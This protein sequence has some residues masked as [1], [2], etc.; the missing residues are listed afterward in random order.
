MS[1]STD[2]VV[3]ALSAA[4]AAGDSLELR[5]ALGD[6]YLALGIGADALAQFEAGLMLSAASSAAL[7]GAVLAA[8]LCGDTARASAY[9]LAAA[10]VPPPV[11]ALASVTTL[12]PTPAP[13]PTPALAPETAA[14]PASTPPRPA[15]T[16]SGVPAPGK[17]PRDS[18][19]HDGPSLRLVSDDG[20]EA[21]P[22]VTFANVGGMEEVKQRLT[23]SFLLPLRNPELVRRF[24]KST[25]GGLLLYGPPGCGK[26]FLARAVAGEVGARF[27]NIG[28]S[29]VLDMW[30]GESERKLHELFENARRG[31]PTLIFL[32]EVDALGQRRSNMKGGAGR[33]LVNQLLSEMDGMAGDNEGVFFLA[34]T[35][36]PWDVDPALRRPGRFD[37][38]V[39][40]SP[41]DEIA[42]RSIFLLKLADR[43]C[44]QDI[45][46]N[47]LGKLSN[48]FSGADVDG[49]V[50]SAAELALE[51]SV[52]KGR[53]IDIDQALLKRALK[54]A[55][56]STRAWFELARNHAIYAN[57]GGTYDDLLAHL[58]TLGLA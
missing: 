51:E 4:L 36:H 58:R 44:T 43:P 56:P 18:S 21:A 46:V 52:A 25:G 11:V 7:A 41:P 5:C 32:D 53:E 20:L 31:R 34:A 12:S 45:D 19:N 3:R 1:N 54:D 48:G 47:A 9:R 33:T 8:E 40:V 14:A 49:V 23:R 22:Q 39:F 6:R 2:P 15:L 42:R 26:T 37:R 57:E 50:R 10:S 30:M 35:N 13:A 38:L 17:A 28:L 29:D 27:L 55:K 16:T 24:G